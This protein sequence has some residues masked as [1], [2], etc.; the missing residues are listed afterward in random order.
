MERIT[1]AKDASLGN[2]MIKIK[3]ILL[4]AELHAQPLARV[5]VQGSQYLVPQVRWSLWV[6]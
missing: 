1:V 4:S 6:Q 5:F 2:A 3:L